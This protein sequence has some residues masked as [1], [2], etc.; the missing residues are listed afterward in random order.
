MNNSLLTDKTF[1]RT[2]YLLIKSS[3]DIESLGRIISARIGGGIPF[4]GLD[5]Y[6]CDEIPAIY[7]SNILGCTLILLGYPGEDGYNL[8]LREDHFPH[9]LFQ[10]EGKPPSTI[11]LS[12]NLYAC[13]K[14]IDDLSVS[15]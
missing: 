8:K 11:D 14:D 4:K 15:L 1:F 13:L 6:I 9:A 12:G 10:A 5:E 7:I 3:L 2:A